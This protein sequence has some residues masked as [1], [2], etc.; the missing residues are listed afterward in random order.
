MKKVLKV[1]KVKKFI[2]LKYLKF[3]EIKY[4]NENRYIN[5]INREPKN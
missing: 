5:P 3:C 1:K 2:L 4:I